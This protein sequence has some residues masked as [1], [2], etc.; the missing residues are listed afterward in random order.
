MSADTAAD[1][2][3]RLEQL[4]AAYIQAENA[5]DVE[6]ILE[7]F[8]D[9]VVIVPPEAPPVRGKDASRAFLGEFLSAFDVELELT[10]EE[11]VVDSDL[12]YDWGTASGTVTPE[13]GEPEAVENS[14]LIIYRREADGAW[15]QRKHV[16]NSNE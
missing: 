15:R 8:S 1:D 5:G 6:G 14:Y 2:I 16:W 10:S 13:G 3:E 9:D 12:A 7:T 4:R 11:I